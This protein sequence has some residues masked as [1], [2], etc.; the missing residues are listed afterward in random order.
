MYDSVRGVF[1]EGLEPYPGSAFKEKTHIQVCVR[2][3]NC[4]KGYFAPILPNKKYPL[5]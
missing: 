3:P 2:N 4:I 5:P 1:E